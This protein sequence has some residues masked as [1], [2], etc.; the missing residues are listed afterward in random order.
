MQRREC[1]AKTE[2]RKGKVFRKETQEVAMRKTWIK[3]QTQCLYVQSIRKAAR[4]VESPKFW[5]QLV[6][7]S[8]GELIHLGKSQK[9]PRAHCSHFQN[10]EVSLDDFQLFPRLE[11]P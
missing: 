4:Y 1:S 10:E 9:L 3:K 7:N 2:Q 5:F 8:L 6:I 11:I